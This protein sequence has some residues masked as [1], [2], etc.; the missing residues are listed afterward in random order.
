MLL[1]APPASAQSLTLTVSPVAYLYFGTYV[2]VTGTVS[3]DETIL[4][5]EGTASATLLVSIN[6]LVK[7]VNIG[8]VGMDS[9]SCSAGTWAILLQSDT[10]NL[11]GGDFKLGRAYVVAGAIICADAF[12][13]IEQQVQAKIQV[14]PLTPTQ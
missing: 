9:F 8:T 13:C 11:D 5:Q 12:G 6:Q 2:R 7:G 1:V 3:C 4:E 14:L 10:T